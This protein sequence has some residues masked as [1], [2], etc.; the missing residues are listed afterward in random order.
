ML[1]DTQSLIL[2]GCITACIFITGVLGIL[3]NFIVLTI[4]TIMLITFA[5]NI[6]MATKSHESE[7]VESE[8]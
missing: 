5:V 1:N 7:E 4:L 2:C 8:E 6:Y 3:D